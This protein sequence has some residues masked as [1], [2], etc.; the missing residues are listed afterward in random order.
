M[1]ASE[2]V[3]SSPEQGVGRRP[4]CLAETGG[5][6]VGEL[7]VQRARCQGALTDTLAA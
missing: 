1:K 2:S 5:S 6:R 4:L 3:E 7:T